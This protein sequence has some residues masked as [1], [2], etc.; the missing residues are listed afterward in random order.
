MSH[1]LI[2]GS[3]YRTWILFLALPVMAG[4]LSP[5]YYNHLCLFV[6][7]LHILYSDYITRIELDRAEHLLQVFYA[8]FS[9]FYGM[10]PRSRFGVIA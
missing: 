9:E 8:Q 3:E 7:A 6:A 10:Y 4:L 2:L 1:T 5:C